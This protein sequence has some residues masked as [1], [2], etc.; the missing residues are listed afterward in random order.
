MSQGQM[1]SSSQHPSESPLLHLGALQHL[2]HDVVRPENKAVAILPLMA[3]GGHQTYHPAS[4]MFSDGS[5]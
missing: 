4:L 1:S 3:P 5:G 2:V